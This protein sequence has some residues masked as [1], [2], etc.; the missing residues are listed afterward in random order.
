MNKLLIHIKRNLI[1]YNIYQSMSK[2]KRSPSPEG[3]LKR[4][5]P[6]YLSPSSLKNAILD[7]MLI[8]YLDNLPQDNYYQILKNSNN[9]NK[10]NFEMSL[11]NLGYKFEENVIKML[12]EKFK[13]K[14]INISTYPVIEQEERTKTEI[15]KGTP[16]IFQAYIKDED[17]KLHGHPDILVRSD[18]LNKLVNTEAINKEQ[19]HISC[20][21]HKRFHYRVVD[22]KF[23]CM[24]LMKNQKNLLN[25]Q[26]TKLYKTQVYIY[27]IILG[28]IQGYTPSQAYILGRRWKN[29]TTKNKEKII[30]GSDN[31]FDRLGIIDF[32]NEDNFISKTVSDAI[33]LKRELIPLFETIT[34]SDR[35][36]LPN[37][38]VLPQYDGGWHEIKFKIAM[39]QKELTLINHCSVSNRNQAISKGILR[40]DDP[41][42]DAKALGIGGDKLSK[43]VDN[44]I[45]ANRDDEKIIPKVLKDNELNWKDNTTLELF[46]DFE[47]VND[48]AM[49]DFSL[50]PD[51]IRGSI[52]YLIGLGW[53][54]ENNK[55]NY[56]SFVTDSLTHEAEKTN[57]NKFINFMMEKVSAL[58]IATLKDVKLYHWG[59]AEK[60]LFNSSKNKHKADWDI[61]KNWIDFCK[62]LKDN[63]VAIKGSFGYSLKS[64]G[65]ALREHNL[66]ET[67]WK[68]TDDCQTALESIT[69]MKAINDIAMETNK[70]I[71]EIPIF[72]SILDY[73]ETDCKVLSEIVHYFKHN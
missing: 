3:P 4:N 7:N 9:D 28:K 36:L 48:L 10:Q 27:S 52:I 69:S 11:I 22:I 24:E 70:K 66:I 55:W 72:Q 47:T 59:H 8:D 25:S 56:K 5:R 73:N 34:L 50:L 64:I 14:T 71:I 6:N 33:V 13:N 49:E 20:H 61:N 44:I 63:N 12:E 32:A 51:A 54:S 35:R 29:I 65:K 45:K 37:M 17:D 19:E 39:E 31:C 1:Y 40:W 15:S 58:G 23:S 42:C 2:R 41:R 57:I 38:N 67:T 26:K 68:I 16:I 18:W 46:V 43:I 21:L 30:N 53:Y 60:S 62:I